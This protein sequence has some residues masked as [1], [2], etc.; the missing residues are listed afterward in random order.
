MTRT[1]SIQDLTDGDWL[2]HERELQVLRVHLF[3]NRTPESLY[4]VGA[5]DPIAP[6]VV[7]S[8]YPPPPK[9]TL[10]RGGLKLQ[11]HFP[12]THGPS[13]YRIQHW[14]ED[15]YWLHACY[16]D[17]RGASYSRFS[18]TESFDALPGR[19]ARCVDIMAREFEIQ[20]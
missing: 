6:S 2:L 8:W 13:W 12:G 11:M 14:S 15:R 9:H 1:N 4:V 7:V 5:G 18:L 20:P 16:V 10:L 3:R 17:H 19:F